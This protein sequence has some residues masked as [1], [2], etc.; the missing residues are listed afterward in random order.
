VAR[1]FLD[2]LLGRS[3]PTPELA[4]A[5][6]ELSRLAQ[7]RPSLANPISFLNELLPI[8]AVSED[9]FPSG[10]SQEQATAKLAEGI[11]LLRGEMSHFDPKSLHARAVKISAALL[12]QGQNDQTADLAEAVR[13]GRL[14][15][16]EIA[17]TVLAGRPETIKSAAERLGID[18]DLTANLVRFTLLPTLV[19]LN[20]ALA[21]FRTG[22][23]WPRGYCPTCGSWP[24]LAEFRGLEQDRWLR[25]GLCAAEWAFP[26][27]A[28][29]FCDNR[30]H[31]T[32]EFVHVEGEE[33]RY[34]AVTCGVC[35]GYV[36]TV[37]TLGAL[38]PLRLL[39]ADVA[40]LHLDLAMAERLPHSLP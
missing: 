1:G 5:L 31:H 25:C 29:P 19:A 39:V 40:T 30:D 7:E 13:S 36:K 21:P 12:R 26:R 24:L 38:S 22:L 3:E 4:D 8:L 20:S 37:A 10:L 28:C 17:P 16:A 14:S 32:L 35:H 11:P 6:A 34:R 15:V 33:G 9:V 2:K 23:A 18:A 27:L